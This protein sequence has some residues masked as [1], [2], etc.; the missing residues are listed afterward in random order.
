MEEFKF[1]KKGHEDEMEYL[2]DNQ[3]SLKISNEKEEFK[4]DIKKQKEDDV[5]K[6]DTHRNLYGEELPAGPTSLSDTAENYIQ[7]ANEIE[8]GLNEAEIYLNNVKAS[9]QLLSNKK[10]NRFFATNDKQQQ[11]QELEK[12]LSLEKETHEESREEI[13]AK[14][15]SINYDEPRVR[16]IIQGHKEKIEKIQHEID[17]VDFELREQYGVEDI[18]LTPATLDHNEAAIYKNIINVR[19][20][21]ENQLKAMKMQIIEQENRN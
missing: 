2:E 17:G 3:D 13:L 7:L 16:E 11:I 5:Q 19:N 1:V 9:L 12:Q 20:T 18:T 21:L 6:R 8:K 14:A 4:S 15:D 10:V